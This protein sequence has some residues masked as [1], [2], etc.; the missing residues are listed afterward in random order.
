MAAKTFTVVNG[1]TGVKH[2]Y[3]A[4][5]TADEAIRDAFRKDTPNRTE[6]CP[7]S[8]VP[9][10]VRCCKFGPRAYEIW[11][12]AVHIKRDYVTRTKYEGSWYS[13][14]RMAAQVADDTQDDE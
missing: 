10:I 3:N 8:G 7:V 1:Q 6:V 9:T 13:V 12:E 14:G 5:T 11:V 2:T 4:T